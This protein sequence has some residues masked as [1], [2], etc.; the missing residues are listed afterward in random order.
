MGQPCEFQVSGVFARATL[1]RHP[2]ANAELDL[3]PDGYITAKSAQVRKP[4]QVGPE[5]GP[6]S[7]FYS[8]IPRGMHG[9]TCTFWANMTPF[10]LQS[11]LPPK[12]QGEVCS[13]KYQCGKSVNLTLPAPKDEWHGMYQ[14][15]TVVSLWS[16]SDDISRASNGRELTMF[17]LRAGHR[18]FVRGI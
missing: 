16:R 18:R 5:V 7:A 17:V 13:P 9:P 2:N 3:F 10:S 6:T 12:F 15:Y 4:H 11:W 1:A 14:D 8:C